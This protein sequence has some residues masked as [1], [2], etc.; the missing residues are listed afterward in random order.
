M[1]DIITASELASWLTRDETANLTLAVEL[2]NEIVSDAWS[3]TEKALPAPAWVRAIAL[4][5]ASRA[6][7]NPK[8][9]SSET[10]SWDD[11]S[12]TERFEG[13]AAAKQQG[14]FLTDEERAD[15]AA[16]EGDG[17]PTVGSITTQAKGWPCL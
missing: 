4:N 1:V 7:V 6:V 3:D 5:V 17:I 10:R 12:R 8:G 13:S 15:L 14:V 9:L 16:D 2:T 11:V